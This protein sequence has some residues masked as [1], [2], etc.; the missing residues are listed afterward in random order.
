MQSG[1]HLLALKFKAVME[2]VREGEN[3]VIFVK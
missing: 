1:G 3:A 2:K